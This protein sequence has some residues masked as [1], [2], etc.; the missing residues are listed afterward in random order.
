MESSCKFGNNEE[1][2]VFETRSDGIL[3]R[4]YPSRNEGQKFNHEKLYRFF[5]VAESLATLSKDP[6]TKVGS[7]VFGSGY[8]IR[9]QGWNGAAR[10]SLA[11]V[12][13]RYSNRDEKL[14]W[15]SHSEANAVCNAARCGTALDGCAIVVTSFPCMGCAKLIV[16]AGI[17]EVLCPEPKGDFLARWSED[18]IRAKLLFAECGVRLVTFE[19]HSNERN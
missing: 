8:E 11:D 17:S 2:E 3:W 4:H 9:S 5:S 16:Q 14:W 10:G 18:I 1:K 19:A 13:K 15:V 6:S 7:L 12:D